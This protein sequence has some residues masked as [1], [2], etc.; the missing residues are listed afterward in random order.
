M[1]VPDHLWHAVRECCRRALKSSPIIF[2]FPPSFED[3]VH[4]FDV[5]IQEAHP[6]RIIHSLFRATT[7][8]QWNIKTRDEVIIA[9]NNND[10]AL[11]SVY[12]P[13][14][15][16]SFW[17]YFV[18]LSNELLEAGYPGCE[19]C[20]QDLFPLEWDEKNSR[21]VLSEQKYDEVMD[22]SS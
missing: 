18:Q 22:S 2:T 16:T 5:R 10:D 21:R 11:T 6:S 14:S 1:G 4:R 9:S 20:V 17:R 15:A 7:N 3:E 8:K 13:L 19:D 12:I